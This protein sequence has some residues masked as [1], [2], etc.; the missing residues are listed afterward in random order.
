MT[1]YD[2]ASWHYGGDFDLALPRE[3]AA[4]HIGLFAAWCVTRGLYDAAS[5]NEALAE[6]LLQRDLTPAAFIVA[7]D[8]KLTDDLLSQRGNEFADAYYDGDNEPC[9]L[10][11]YVDVFDEIDDIYAVPDAWESFE[12]IESVLDQRFA[13]FML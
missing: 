11:D 1:T 10:D 3:A 6:E 7:L 4:T 5:V 12:R 2:D 8:E 9:Y 13:S